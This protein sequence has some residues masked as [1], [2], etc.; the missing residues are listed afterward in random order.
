MFADFVFVAEASDMIGNIGPRAESVYFGTLEEEQFFVGTPIAIENGE[1]ILFD[2]TV[3]MCCGVV[4][5]ARF[6]FRETRDAKVEVATGWVGTSYT[7]LK[8]I[9]QHIRWLHMDGARYGRRFAEK[10]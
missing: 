2:N 10:H 9:S 3:G 5:V 8:V 1:G 7:D 6:A 4:S